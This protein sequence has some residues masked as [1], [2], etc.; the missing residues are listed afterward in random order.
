M[1]INSTNSNIKINIYFKLIIHLILILS[2]IFINYNK[3]DLILL[4]EN[5]LPILKNMNLE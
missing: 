2:F 5:Y 3:K 1:E 4:N